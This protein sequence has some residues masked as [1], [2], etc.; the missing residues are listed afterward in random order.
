M[1]KSM[2]KPTKQLSLFNP[3]SKQDWKP[4][5]YQKRIIKFGLQNACA[6]LFLDPGLGK[7]SICLAII[8]V[9]KK[10][11]MMNK[12]LIIAPLRVCYSV[13]PKEIS[14][15]TDFQNITVE[16]LHGA[17]KEKALQREADIYLIN[18]EGL[19]WLCA[20]KF[21]T[22]GFDILIIDESSKFKAT[23]TKRFKLLRNVLQGFR[24]RYVLTGT[25]V[26]NGL[27]DLF[28]QIYILDMGAALGRYITHYRNTYFYPSGFGGYEWKLQEGAEAKIKER[29]R[30][31]T[32]HLEDKDYLELPEIVINDIY[33]DL[34]EEARAIYDE[35]E[36]EMIIAW[37][38][39]DITAANAAAASNKCCQI[40]NGGIYDEDSKSH[41]VHTAKV[42]VVEEL[43]EELSGSPA[44]IS[45]DFHHDL[46][47]LAAVLGKNLPY[48]GGGVS[49]KRAAQLEQA[50]NAGE[51]PYL[52]GNPASISHGLNLQDAGNHV[53]LP[54][55]TWNFE[56]YD[57]FIKRV[58]RQGNKHKKV[59]V[60]RI[61]ARDTVDEAK[62]FTLAAKGSTQR[63][64]LAGL[65]EYLTHRNIKK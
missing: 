57:Q 61:I 11:K 46:E 41:V 28:G 40:A 56:H 4:H 64:L 60:H 58:R 6:G 24:R 23:N 49:T 52:I 62:I 37:D 21:R 38:A 1:S 22:L 32:V 53:I 44:L 13:W 18:P 63:N 51:L 17:D 3:Q 29:I 39:G 20:K 5:A 48:I 33:I 36:K 7:T 14:K 19:P 47:R 27:M 65:K 30:P 2:T 59:F 26:P 43:L 31:F 8:K 55:L 34:P 10:E 42:G 15:W 9:L 54:S 35:M 16:I 45:Y 12:A 50:W 25:P